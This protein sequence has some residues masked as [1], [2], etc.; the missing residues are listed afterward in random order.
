MRYPPFGVERF[1]IKILSFSISTPILAK[2]FLSQTTVNCYVGMAN[3]GKS[4]F[5]NQLLG[6]DYCRSL[7]SQALPRATTSFWPGTTVNT[8]KFPITFL[9]PEKAKQR[10][11]RLT[12]DNIKFSNYEEKRKKMYE[13][14]MDLKYAEC[15]G[16]V[17]SSFQPFSQFDEQID[18]NVDATYALDARTG[19]ISQG[20]SY[21]SRTQ[22]ESRRVEQARS[23]YDPK[24][25]RNRATWF[26]DTPGVLGELEML[27]L[28]LYWNLKK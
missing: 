9:T 19:E 4:V 12:N 18:V 1:V 26:H 15:K 7:A 25:Y 24:F 5:F 10:S 6:S 27:R 21:E 20:E 2:I 11:A 17:G 28:A 16:K 8:L 13:K 14:T 3:A 22:I 23:V